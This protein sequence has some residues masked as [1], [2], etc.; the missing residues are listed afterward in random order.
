MKL[1]V[2]KFYTWSSTLTV[3]GMASMLWVVLGTLSSAFS[4]RYPGWF[5]LLLA[6]VLVV[7]G[8]LVQQ[9]SA[10]G[11]RE[12]GPG[13]LARSPLWMVNACLVYTTTLG[14]AHAV[15]P[16]TQAQ[17]EDRV[18]E[19]VV[20]ASSDPAQAEP[21]PSAAPAPHGGPSAPPEVHVQAAE[22]SDTTLHAEHTA[23]RPAPSGP[24]RAP[25]TLSRTEAPLATR[26][27]ESELAV[28]LPEPEPTARI[29]VPPK[30]ARVDLSRLK[31]ALQPPA[32]VGFTRILDAPLL[33]AEP[34]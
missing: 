18:N 25:S 30:A 15:L 10:K 21:P 33:A 4:W 13:W 2:D 12:K 34:H 26:A 14:G 19:A 8:D 6:L 5:P 22:P 27:A 31:Q 28:P 1:E 24:R 3:A 17:T 29:A 32:R 16:S 23:P 7:T 11:K 20:H 9:S